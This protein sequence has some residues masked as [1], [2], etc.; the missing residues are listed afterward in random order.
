MVKCCRNSSS[1]EAKLDALRSFFWCLSPRY[2][3]LVKTAKEWRNKGGFNGYTSD[4]I[5]KP[6]RS[7][8]SMLTATFEN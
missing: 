8:A 3:P 6:K 7:G 1:A 4:W 2:F 5:R